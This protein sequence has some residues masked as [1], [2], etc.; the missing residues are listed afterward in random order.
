MRVVT[1][2]LICLF[3]GAFLSACAGG[4][5]HGS[6]AVVTT[7]EQPSPGAYHVN[8]VGT[9]SCALLVIGDG[10]LYKADKGCDGSV[11]Y[12]AQSVEVYPGGAMVDAAR[13]R[14]TSV[15]P[16]K[17]TGVWTLGNFTANIVGTKRK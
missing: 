6:G 17:F 15:E 16:N 9:N 10:A 14:F 3:V 12:T 4:A 11:S 1:N 13:I 7:N 5:G 8:F 2:I